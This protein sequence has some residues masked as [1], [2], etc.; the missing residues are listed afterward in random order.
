MRTVSVWAVIQILA[1]GFSY[2]VLSFP[3]H[4]L[5]CGLNCCKTCPSYWDFLK[6]PLLPQDVLLVKAQRRLAS[7][8][9]VDVGLSC[10][11]GNT[12]TRLA[13]T[14]LEADRSSAFAKP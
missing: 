2:G 12:G 6:A 1:L 4:S 7:E 9:L 5:V 3:F 10:E 8:S 11:L 14:R 13:K